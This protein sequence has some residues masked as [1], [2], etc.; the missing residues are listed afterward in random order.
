MKRRDRM[1][2]KGRRE[3]GTFTLIPHAVQNSP[4][5]MACSGT[6]IKL[7]LELARQFRGY[8]NGD[9]CASIT[10]LRPRGWT[11]PE[12]ITWALRELRHYGLIEQTRQ[13]GLN[14]ASLYALTWYAIDECGGKLEVRATKVAS[15]AWRMPQPLFKRPTRKRNASTESVLARN[16]IRSSKVHSTGSADTETVAIRPP[17]PT[18]ATTESVHLLDSNQAKRGVLS[19]RSCLFSRISLA[20]AEAKPGLRESHFPMNR[21][22]VPLG[23]SGPL[24]RVR[25]RYG[26]RGR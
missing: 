22:D 23:F 25:A 1:K 4:N 2:S 24:T 16:G 11:S 8:N 3:S 10:I 14:A 19:L 20:S 21:H 15:G 9:L 13:G 26:V 18:F 12:T 7:L 17:N 5:W 6:A